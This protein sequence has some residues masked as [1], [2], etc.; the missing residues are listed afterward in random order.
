[1]PPFRRHGPD[2]EYLRKGVTEWLPGWKRNGWKTGEKKPVKNAG[3]WTR[4]D[5]AAQ[6]QRS[7]RCTRGP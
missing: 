6:N 5:S 1:M 3:L 7:R 2:S 4:L